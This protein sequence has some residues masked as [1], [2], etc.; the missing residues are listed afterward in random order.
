MDKK[1][2]IILLLLGIFFTYFNPVFAGKVLIS[3]AAD[4]Q[5]EGQGQLGFYFYRSRPSL[6]FNFGLPRLSL[7]VK[8]NFSETNRLAGLFKVAVLEET[9]DQPGLAFGA[10]IGFGERHLYGVVSKQLGLPGLRGHLALGTGK[11]ARGM[12]AVSFVLNPVNIKT[13]NGLTLPVTSAVLEYDG[14]GLNG[15]LAAQ[16]S[17][18][19]KA[20]LILSD[21]EQLNF[22]LN[23]K[24]F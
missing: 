15:G 14:R 7:G 2:L 17:P 5:A 10:E 18:G 3:P 12:A 21:F 4:L 23:Y 22:G 13:E 1:L 9:A 6:E 19:L 20:F 8:N 11:Y 16:F 24:F